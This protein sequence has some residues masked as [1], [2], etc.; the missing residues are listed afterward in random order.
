MRKFL[1]WPE[2][3]YHMLR[4]LCTK[5]TTHLFG[6]PAND[7]RSNFIKDFMVIEQGVEWMMRQSDHLFFFS[8]KVFFFS[9]SIFWN[10]KK[11][12]NMSFMLCD[13]IFKNWIRVR[14]ACTY[15][16]IDCSNI[17][18]YMF[19]VHLAIYHISID[20]IVYSMW[21]CNVPQIW[22]TCPL[23]CIVHHFLSHFLLIWLI[24][25][26]TIFFKLFTFRILALRSFVCHSIQ[27]E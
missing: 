5:L 25:C 2:F 18:F 6:R 7:C 27:Q 23:W 3:H 17:I 19:H 8:C 26:C 1:H 9:L 10:T 4:M 20:I 22:R 16:S 12:W 21:T 11:K 14:Y 13:G 15:C 24:G